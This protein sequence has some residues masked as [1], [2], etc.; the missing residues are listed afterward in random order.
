[1]FKKI[2]GDCWARLGG[3]ESIVEWES[4][5]LWCY[6]RVGEKWDRVGFMVW[7]CGWKYGILWMAI[8]VEYWDISNFDNTKEI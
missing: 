8:D 2:V 6:W 1:M 7:E 5:C 3:W 4:S